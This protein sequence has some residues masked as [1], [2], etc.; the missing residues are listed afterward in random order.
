MN[1]DTWDVTGGN[2]WNRHPPTPATPDVDE[3][4]ADD[5]A[6]LDAAQAQL[7][8]MRKAHAEGRRITGVLVATIANGADSE[9]SSLGLIHN[10]MSNQD[11]EALHDAIQARLLGVDI[12]EFVE[13][14][15]MMGA[16]DGLLDTDAPWG[17]DEGFRDIFGDDN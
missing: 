7:D 6:F 11:M 1:D 3:R 10:P 15:G 13:G 5:V 14:G 12:K 2:N 9:T 16:L 4:L 17:S 8:D